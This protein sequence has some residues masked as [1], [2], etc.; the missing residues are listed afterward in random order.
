MG[1]GLRRDAELGLPRLFLLGRAAEFDLIFAILAIATFFSVG[2]FDYSRLARP[3]SKFHPVAWLLA[4]AIFTCTIEGRLEASARSNAGKN[5]VVSSTVS[6]WP[7][8]ARA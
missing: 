2:H 4:I 8:K 1:R 3:I 7:P 6:P 5:S